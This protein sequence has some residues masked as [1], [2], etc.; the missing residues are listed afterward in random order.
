M[1]SNNKCSMVEEI[2]VVNKKK[3]RIGACIDFGILD[4][5]FEKYRREKNYFQMRKILAFH[6]DE[7]STEV[8]YTL[9][10]RLWEFISYS[11]TLS[12]DFIRKFS[13]KVNWKNISWSQILTESFIR[14]FKDKVDWDFISYRQILSE[15]FMREFADKLNWECITQTQVLSEQFI[16]D[17]KDKL[18]LENMPLCNVPG[19]LEFFEQYRTQNCEI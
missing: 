17:F 3:D 7:L 18:D 10:R 1:E 15:D 2:C 6:L 12:E 8:I 13:D 9:S 11:V 19:A 5:L 16:F 4:D 14:E